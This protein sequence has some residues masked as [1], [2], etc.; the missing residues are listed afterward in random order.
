MFFRANRK[1]GTGYSLV[2]VEEVFEWDDETRKLYAI[3]IQ[4]LCNHYG[5]INDFRRAGN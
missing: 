3:C 4:Q 2:G 5:P 1:N